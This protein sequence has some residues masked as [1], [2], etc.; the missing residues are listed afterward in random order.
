MLMSDH[1]AH[2]ARPRRRRFNFECELE[3]RP[4]ITERRRELHAEGQPLFA[5]A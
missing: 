1:L 4:F 3:K 2:E 5:S